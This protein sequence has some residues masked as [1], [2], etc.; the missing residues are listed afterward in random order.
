MRPTILGVLLLLLVAPA[1][2]AER[3]FYSGYIGTVPA[4][5]EDQAKTYFDRPEVRHLLTALENGPVSETTAASILSARPTSLSDLKRLGLVR[6]GDGGLRIGF[7][8]FT[9]NDMALVHA[10][11]QRY[12]PSLVAAYKAKSPELDASLAR[13]G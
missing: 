9:P 7:P 5:A 12:V 11:A 3:Q 2:A 6:T 1:R 8:Y 10:V 4:G 13:Y